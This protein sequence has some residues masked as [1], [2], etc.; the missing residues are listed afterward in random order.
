MKK[1]LR[2]MAWLCSMLFCFSCA[3][4]ELKGQNRKIAKRAIQSREYAEQQNQTPALQ[5]LVENLIA[6]GKK[7]LGKPYRYKGPAQRPM[8][9]SGFICHIFGQYNI[10]LPPSSSGQYSVT[11]KIQ[12][13]EP[14]DLLFFTGRNRN[15]GRVGH[16]AMVIDVKGD[17]VTM[18]HSTNSR[19]IIIEKLNNSKYFSS[20]FIGYGRVKD[21]RKETKSDNGS[22]NP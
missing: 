12:D 8:D 10:A 2:I 21:L 9:C 6:E 5:D 22:Q 19:G 4:T 1:T 11:E 18:M 17:E 7:F 16:V 15:S 14:G 13:P 3:H 20:R